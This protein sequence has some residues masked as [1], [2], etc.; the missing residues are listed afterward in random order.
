MKAKTILILIILL[1]FQNC[2][3]KS[4]NQP[5]QKIS[6]IKKVKVPDSHNDIEI[7]YFSNN[8]I[9][10]TKCRKDFK[11]CK[12]INEYLIENDSIL[13]FKKSGKRC[14]I[15]SFAP[16]EE[17]K[18]FIGAYLFEENYDFHNRKN[19]TVCQKEM[20]VYVEDD[21][22]LVMEKFKSS[23]C[24]TQIVSDKKYNE[25]YSEFKKLIKE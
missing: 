3:T 7:T 4:I 22:I 9:R 23:Q 11:N 20:P 8:V 12:L 16:G 25:I 15:H 2:K 21:K 13:T 19:K 17:K 1:L 5:T 10:Y 18:N 24:N 6:I 14:L